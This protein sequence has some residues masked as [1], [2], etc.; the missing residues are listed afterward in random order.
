MSRKIKVELGPR[1]YNGTNYGGD[2]ETTSSINVLVVR[3]GKI[4]ELMTIRWYMGRSRSASQMY[5]TVWVHHG[6]DDRSGSGT[7][8]GYGYDKRSAAFAD[9]L[10]DANI[11]YSGSRSLA[12]MSAVRATCDA[13]VRKLGYRSKPYFV[14]N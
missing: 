7:A 6:G 12:G 14:E 4:V 8:G 13:I 3:Q 1:V 10:E 11:E 9:A 5:C 2:K